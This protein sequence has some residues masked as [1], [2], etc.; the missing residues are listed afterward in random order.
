MATAQERQ[1]NETGV[2]Q[3]RRRAVKGK[4]NDEQFGIPMAESTRSRP[5]SLR[6]RRID[7]AWRKQRN[8]SWGGITA[9]Q[10]AY[11]HRPLQ[12]AAQLSTLL[13]D[14]GR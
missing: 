4:T 5:R 7:R 10:G 9:S 11:M 3:Q 14:E 2:A 13:K 6:T 1:D 8:R 12:A